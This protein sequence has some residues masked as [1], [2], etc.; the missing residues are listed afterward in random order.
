MC[1]YPHNHYIFVYF[2]KFIENMSLH[3]LECSTMVWAI[4]YDFSF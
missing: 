2:F 4:E 1:E 3:F